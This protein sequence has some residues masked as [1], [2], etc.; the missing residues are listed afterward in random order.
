MTDQESNAP[1]CPDWIWLISSN[2]HVA[3]DRGWVTTYTPFDSVLKCSLFISPGHL[4]VLGV[5]TVEIPTKCSPNRS[6]V[7]SHGSLKLEEVLHVPDFPCNAVG[8]NI[9]DDYIVLLSQGKTK[10]SIKNSQG[11]NIAYFDR[12]R[13]LMTIKVSHRAGG[14]KLGPPVLQQ[15]AEYTISCQWESKEQQRWLM[16]QLGSGRSN[17]KANPEGAADNNSPY[18]GAEKD[19]LKAHWRDEYDFLF[20]HGLSIYKEENRAKGR[21]LLRS[22]MSADNPD[23]NRLDQGTSEHQDLPEE[24]V[25]Q[26]ERIKKHYDSSSTS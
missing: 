12:N 20:A 5:G 22:L 26:L 18:T 17:P 2:V 7:A 13:P 9:G 23:E 24:F 15:G 19:Y 21:S 8:G 14:P 4:P 1:V 11:K 10:G 3:K 16:H 6:G 25:K